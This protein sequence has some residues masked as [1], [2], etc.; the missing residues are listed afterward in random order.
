MWPEGFYKSGSMGGE[1]ILTNLLN[2]GLLI[3]IP[4]GGASL[5]DINYKRRKTQWP[6]KA[7]NGINSYKL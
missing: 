5:S 6:R 7:P 2:G 4:P 3:F 1:T